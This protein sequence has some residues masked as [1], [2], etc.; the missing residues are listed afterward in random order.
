M[1]TIHSTV[2]MLESLASLAGFIGGLVRP[3]WWPPLWYTSLIL[4]FTFPILNEIFLSFKG[5]LFRYRILQPPTPL[6]DDI[7]PIVYSPK[8]NIHA[9]G[10][11]K[12]HPFDASKYRRVFEDLVESGTIDTKNMHLHSPEVPSREFL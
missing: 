1:G 9:F 2:C 8:Y 7:F 11:E 6:A 3:D 10:L 5:Y 12:L 4:F